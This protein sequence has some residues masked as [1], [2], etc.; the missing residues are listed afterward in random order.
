MSCVGVG[1][2][3]ISGEEGVV[4]EDVR[5]GNFIERLVSERELAAARIEKD[6]VV[7]EVGGGGNE[8]LE[9]EG[10]E[11]AAGGEV[12]PADAGFEEVA[13]AECGGLELRQLSRE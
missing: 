6:E 13:E 3:G 7:G 12:A 2:A 9:E 4:G 5:V 1:Q 10:V 8:G 11:G